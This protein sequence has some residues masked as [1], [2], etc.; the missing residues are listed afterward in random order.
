MR[1]CDSLIFL[2][3]PKYVQPGSLVKLDQVQMEISGG[4]CCCFPS[5]KQWSGIICNNSTSCGPF[6]N[7][8]IDSRCLE[9]LPWLQSRRSEQQMPWDEQLVGML[10]MIKHPDCYT[11]KKFDAVVPLLSRS[12]SSR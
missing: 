10:E 3:N 8:Q 6:A 11:K 4:L 12:R 9:T 1:Q 7:G 2:L 5:H